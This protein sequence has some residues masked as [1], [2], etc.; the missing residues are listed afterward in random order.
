MANAGYILAGLN[1]R[2]LDDR[3]YRGRAS[4]GMLPVLADRIGL[5][6]V[7]QDT[8]LNG[9]GAGVRYLSMHRP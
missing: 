1:E 6:Q 4:E 3:P 7:H 9:L 5:G 2:L 8:A